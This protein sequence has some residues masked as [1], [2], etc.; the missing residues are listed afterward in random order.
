MGNCMGKKN[1][2]LIATEPVAEQIEAA[3][4]PYKIVL[5]GDK[6]VGKT[7]IVMRYT[8]DKWSTVHNVTIGATFAIKDLVIKREDDK[9]VKVRLHIWDT[10]GEE[11]YRSMTRYFYTDAI[12]GIVCYDST[13]QDTVTNLEK[14]IDDLFEVSKDVVVLLAGNKIDGDKQFPSAKMQVYAD[15]NRFYFSECSAKTGEG[16][17]ELF[18]KAA[19]LAYKQSV[20]YEGN[21]TVVPE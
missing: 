3:E 7:S 12:V 9:I 20:G 5:I 4:K 19:I 18:D 15:S 8:Q 11:Q 14:W 17:H 13:N 16:I 21:V 2:P 10:A 1:E 6:A